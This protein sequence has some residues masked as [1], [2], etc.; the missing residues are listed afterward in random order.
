M[1]K[2]LAFLLAAIMLVSLVA[3][4]KGGENKS[5]SMLGSYDKSSSVYTNDLLG[6][7]F[8][9]NK[10]WEIFDEKQIAE[11]NGMV[12]DNLSLNEELSDALEK[13]GSVQ[14]FYAQRDGGLVTAN[15][16]IENIGLVYGT[17]IDEKTYAENSVD[18]VAPALE[19][20]GMTDVETKIVT[21][22]FAGE[23]HTAIDI[24]ASLFGADFYETMVCVKTGNYIA[25][26]TV[27]SYITDETDDV[28]SMFSA[29]D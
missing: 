12:K 2:L 14:V 7:R 20:M 13:S 26:V 10:D 3:C 27:G 8:S 23:D 5:D 1:K 22:N 29:L 24:H 9:M 19:T 6:V 18:Q 15:I 21:V 25:G 17:L 28:L 11:L 16:V 4:S